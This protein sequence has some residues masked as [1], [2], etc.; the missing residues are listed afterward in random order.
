[1]DGGAVFTCRCLCVNKEGGEG[2]Y[3]RVAVYVSTKRMGRGC[4]HVSLFMCQQRWAR[5]GSIRRVLSPH[6]AVPTA[7][8]YSRL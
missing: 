6:H 3:S 2:R 5:R 4:V 8:S 7:R 1:M